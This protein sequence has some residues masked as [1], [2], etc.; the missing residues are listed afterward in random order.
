MPEKSFS[1]EAQAE[2]DA[3]AEVEALAK[4]NKGFWQVADTFARAVPIIGQVYA[5]AD[6]LGLTTGGTA[7]PKTSPFKSRTNEFFATYQPQIGVM[8]EDVATAFYKHRKNIAQPP[9]VNYQTFLD[10]VIFGLIVTGYAN[11]SPS[12]LGT[13]IGNI[14]IDAGFLNEGAT[15]N[16]KPT[17]NVTAFQAL[18]RDVP[19]AMAAYKA[20]RA[21]GSSMLGG[22]ILSSVSISKGMIPGVKKRGSSLLPVALIAGAAFLGYRYVKR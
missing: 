6:G 20:Y 19:K 12:K 9:P 8:P 5:I 15:V 10:A 16:G 21:A 2:F 14:G 4:G 11:A 7:G 1:F 17:K 13:E 3:A 18:I 22:G